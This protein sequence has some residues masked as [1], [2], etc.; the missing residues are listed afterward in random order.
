MGVTL[1]RAAGP[2]PGNEQIPKGGPADRVPAMVTDAAPAAD[3]V[4]TAPPTR[5]V[6]AILAT[7]LCFVP[8]GLIAV[9]FAWRTSVLNRRG[10]FTRARRT[11]RAALGWSITTIVIGVIVDAIL[12]ASLGLLGAFGT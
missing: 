12:A 8:L 10:E 7:C 5:L 1:G 9:A 6:W 11:S 2:C 3:E 4:Q